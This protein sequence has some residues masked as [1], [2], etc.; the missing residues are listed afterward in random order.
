MLSYALLDVKTSC[1]SLTRKMLCR[2]DDDVVCLLNLSYGLWLGSLVTGLIGALTGLG[3]GGVIV[4]LLAL[5]FGVDIRYANFAEY[6][7]THCT[8]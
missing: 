5:G 4:P 7:R 2:P 3:G 1:E 6:T 8:T